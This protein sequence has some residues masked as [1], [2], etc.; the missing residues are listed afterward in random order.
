MRMRWSWFPAIFVLAT[1][2]GSV[3][4]RVLAVPSQGS[5]SPTMAPGSSRLSGDNVWTQ[6]V[7]DWDVRALVLSPAVVTDHTVFAGVFGAGIYRSTDGGRLWSLSSSGLDSLNI[8]ALDVSP[9]YTQNATL[10]A[11]TSDAGVFMSFDGGE[12]WV[13]SSVGLTDTLIADVAFSPAYGAD[14]TIFAAAYAGVFTTTNT[15]ISWSYV[16]SGPTNLSVLAVSPGYASDGLIF[17]GTNDA[18]IYKSA[19]RGATWQ[20]A[21]TGITG[22]TVLALA[23]SPAFTSDHTMVA[24][25][26]DVT[27]QGIYKSSNGGESWT[28]LTNTLKASSLAF[29]PQY[30]L[31]QTI[32]AA[33][34]QNAAGR[35]IV[36]RSTS[37]G[38]TW[39]E[40]NVGLDTGNVWVFRLAAAGTTPLTLYAGSPSGGGVWQYSYTPPTTPT[41]SP[42]ATPTV[43][44]TPS[45]TATTTATP[46]ITRTPSRS[47]TGTITA[48][49]TRTGTVTRTGT[50]TGT[51]TRTATRTPTASATRTGTV[52]RTGTATGTA[53]RTATPTQTATMTAS[54]TIT[55]TPPAGYVAYVNVGGSNYIGQDGQKWSADQAFAAGSWGYVDAA[56]PKLPS[57][58]YS[59]ASPIGATSD[60]ALYQS[61]R[62]GMA[63]YRFTVLSGPYSVTLK[64]VET[65]F[66]FGS[67]R[68]F[69]VLI[70][71]A[72]FLPSF[73]IFRSA[74][75]KNIAYDRSFPTDVVDGVLRIEFVARTDQ[76]AIG[77]ISVL[78]IV[79]ATATPTPTT[80]MTASPTLTFTATATATS[81]PTATAT[82][83]ALATPTLTA[84]S[85]MTP[86][87]SATAQGSP[88]TTAT[89]TRTSTAAATATMTISATATPMP[90]RTL[91]AMATATTTNA[92]TATPTRTSTAT[93][94]ATM[95]ISATPTRTRTSTATATPTPTATP[96]AQASETPT[97]TTTAT[98][99]VWTI[100]LPLIGVRSSLA[101]GA[102]A[103]TEDGWLR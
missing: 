73:D 4:P 72:T 75:G 79:P 76:P 40:M 86:A 90:T 99:G 27:Q 62:Y 19:D 87:A 53:T 21:N 94:T 48:T 57:T 28:A 103:L 60:D 24:A 39:A 89:P 92:A 97:P 66:N 100:W 93:A 7:A 71:G 63:S 61:G 52:T 70:Q 12:T 29:S 10:I 78:Q 30:A 17:A 101:P 3:A 47:A 96:S 54:P 18:G 38:L 32:F 43:S 49:S 14:S 23:L 33:T 55:P 58:I 98:P 2:L 15:G 56:P 9:Q 102:M 65:Y 26:S 51:A 16:A 50:A 31:D 36:Y 85:T 37:G 8:L 44:A 13:P 22:T 34:I 45:A 11:T 46:T 88:T 82:Q 42:S 95:T 74:G 5:A 25:I 41:P 59:T 84:T 80:T 64:F 67:A 6:L 69:D 20:P 83:T 68:V 77:A 1:V 91:T 35:N 81:T